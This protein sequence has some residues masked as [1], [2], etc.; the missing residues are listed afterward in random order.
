MPHTTRPTHWRAAPVHMTM[1]AKR[2][3]PSFRAESISKV[4]PVAVVAV[5]MT[6]F[7]RGY[8]LPA[9]AFFSLNLITLFLAALLCHTRLA[10]SRRLYKTAQAAR[11]RSDFRR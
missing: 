11:V 1:R 2:G 3:F 8:H 6:F 10:S 4:L 5:A 7:I 9:L